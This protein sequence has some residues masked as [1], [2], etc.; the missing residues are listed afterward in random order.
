MPVRIWVIQWTGFRLA[1]SKKLNRLPVLHKT[2][3]DNIE[4][5]RFQ[6]RDFHRLR[7]DGRK[8]TSKDFN[9]EWLRDS[10]SKIALWIELS[11]IIPPLFDSSIESRPKLTVKFFLQVPKGTF[12]IGRKEN[13]IYFEGGRLEGGR[14][15]F[16]RSPTDLNE[17]QR[18][19]VVRP[20]ESKIFRLNKILFLRRWKK[21]SYVT[22]YRPMRPMKVL[23]PLIL[24][25]RSAKAVMGIFHQ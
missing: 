12:L 11:N 21:R 19:R 4:R 7:K 2:R 9:G 13:V 15:A 23:E 5:H 20:T 6:L 10:I 1:P 18:S 14:S 3:G 16:T 25:L 24:V 17:V 8:S 22:N